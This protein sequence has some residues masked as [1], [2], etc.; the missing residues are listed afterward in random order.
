MP[1]IA[2]TREM[3]SGGREVAQRVADKLGLTIV[4]HHLVEHD[5]AEHL[6]VRES[7]VHHLLE[8]GATLLDRLRVGSKK[9]AHYKAEEVLDL[10]NRGNVL[11]RGWGS[12]VVLR[13]VPHVVRVRVCA[14]MEV[15]ERA[16]MQRMGSDDRS[17]ARHEI[18]RN[19]SAHKIALHS[20]HGVDREDSTLYDLVLNTERSSI[21][22]CAKLVCDLVDSAEFHETEFSRTIL[23]D[24][25]LEAHVRLRL[26]ERFGVGTG[27]SGVEATANAGKIVLTGMAIHSALVDDASKLAGAIAGVKAVENQ[28]VVVRGPRP[29]P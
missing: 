25:T 8:G 4:L 9:L 16:V 22:T 3:G 5:I 21:E 14:P 24:K 29:L 23:N 19:D 20:A 2:M 7:A 1:V 28:M 18:E 6:H 15:R 12:C 10:A 11:I 26:R 17:A 13:G 27:V